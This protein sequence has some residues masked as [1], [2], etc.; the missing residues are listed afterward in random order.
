MSDV[1]L[2]LVITAEA[3]VVKA[4]PPA[5]AGELDEHVEDVERQDGEE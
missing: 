2:G 3:E 5:D 1:T 4:G